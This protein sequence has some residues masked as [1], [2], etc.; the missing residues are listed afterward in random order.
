MTALLDS[1]TYAPSSPDTATRLRVV[2]PGPLT[3]LQDAGRAGLAHLGIGGCG[4]ADRA[5]AALANRL[6]GNP[7]G[8]PLLENVMGGLTVAT[9]S[10]RYVSVT[11]APAEVRVDG[12]IVAEPQRLYLHAGQRLSIARPPWGVRVYVAIAGGLA[13]RQVFGS[14]STDSL[15]GLGPP[16]LR[17]GDELQVGAVVSDPPSARL[18]LTGTA[19]PTGVI[20][21]GFRWGPRDSLFS[22]ADMRTLTSTTWSV[23][24]DSNRVGVRLTGPALS[25][26]VVNLPSEGMPLGAIQVPPSG[27][28]IVFLADHPVTGGY[29][30]I[31]VVTEPDLDLLAQAPPGARVSFSAMAGG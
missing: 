1:R 28:P 11:G 26:G 10:P 9:S 17:T 18:E 29:P 25:I 19:L 13:G 27:Q 8:A 23:G 16:A 2:D 14:C 6:V 4:P 20:D 3:T 12:S 5:A 30:V 31:G 15:S 22:T 7:E 24:A 21:L